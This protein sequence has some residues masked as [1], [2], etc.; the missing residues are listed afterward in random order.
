MKEV[1]VKILEVDPEGIRKKLKENRA[2]F[3]KNVFQRN[4]FYENSHTREKNLSLRIR[5]EEGKAIITLKGPVEIKGGHKIREEKEVSTKD[6]EEAKKLFD[7]M[8][9]KQW[10]VTEARR[11]YYIL[12]GCSVE[13]IKIPK[14]P[15]FIEIEGS[16][17]NIKKVASKLGYSE[18]DYCAMSA[19]E[20]YSKVTGDNASRLVFE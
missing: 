18:K 7:A 15:I 5:E 10:G 11:E 6:L 19:L 12:D 9:L 2:G 16:E 3:V 4:I 14:L 13:I 17:E 1:E 20:Y 8:G